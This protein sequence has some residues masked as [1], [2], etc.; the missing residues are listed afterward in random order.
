[1]LPDGESAHVLKH[2]RRGFEFDDQPQEVLDQLV[3]RVVE[4][5]L[6]DH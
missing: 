1:M 2:E 5:A 6:A 4:G 3:A